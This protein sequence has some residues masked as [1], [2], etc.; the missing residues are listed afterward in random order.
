M[1]IYEYVCQDCGEAYE[2]LVRS[3]TA[4]VEVTCPKCGSHH[5]EKA[6]SV[7]GAVGTSSASKSASSYSAPAAACGPVG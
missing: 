7:F 5:A 4:K 6:L 2:K 1:P 3:M